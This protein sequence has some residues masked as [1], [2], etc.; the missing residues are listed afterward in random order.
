MNR[1]QAE[2]VITIVDYVASELAAATTLEIA[3][4]DQRT[5]VKDGGIRR[6]MAAGLYTSVTAAEKNIE[7][8]T[9]YMAHRQAQRVAIRERIEAQGKLEA[10][11]MRARLAVEAY[12]LSNGNTDDGDLDAS[13]SLEDY[14]AEAAKLEGVVDRIYAMLDNASIQDRDKD[15]VFLSI[16]ARIALLIEEQMAG[17]AS[18]KVS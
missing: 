6:L 7:F 13:P 10:A 3:L 8:D 11:K 15:G 14:K 2:R 1:D 12:A 18:R 17:Q 16:E 9:E 5:I 4:E